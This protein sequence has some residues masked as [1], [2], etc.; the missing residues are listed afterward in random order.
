MRSKLRKIHLSELDIGLLKYLHAVKVSTYDRTQRDVYPDHKLTSV[1]NRLRKIHDNGLIEIEHGRLLL[2]GKRLVRLS[3][4]G[5]QSYVQR[6]DEHRVEL[7]SDSLFHDLCLNDIKF[8]FTQCSDVIDYR[9][10]NQIQTWGDKERGLN[11]D[12]MIT[13]SKG[14]AQFSMAIEYERSHK[15]NQKYESLVTK[16]Y[17]D[18]HTT[19]VLFFADTVQLLKKV[20]GIEKQLYPSTKPKF[21]YGIYA[22][23]IISD[24]LEFRNFNDDK[25]VI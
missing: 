7:K 2:G 21:F 10:E 5:F 8:R 4:T 15:P 12:A 20:T 14:D 16:Y 24:P 1:G 23:L 11:S 18:S 3:Q 19:G 13:I 22:N 25:L 6:G 17:N 9:T